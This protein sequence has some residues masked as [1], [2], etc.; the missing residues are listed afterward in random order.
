MFSA[1]KVGEERERNPTRRTTESERLSTEAWRKSE[2]QH[3]GEKPLSNVFVC[4][5]IYMD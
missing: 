1:G 3:R 5:S 2:H 4:V